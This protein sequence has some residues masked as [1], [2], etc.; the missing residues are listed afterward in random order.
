MFKK[1][2]LA[3]GLAL[4]ATCAQATTFT[5]DGVEY[6]QVAGS[7]VSNYNGQISTF[8]AGTYLFADVLGSGATFAENVAS[9]SATVFSI[10]GPDS[11]TSSTGTLTALYSNDFGI[12]FGSPNPGEELFILHV[13][14]IS[15]LLGSPVD[16]L[17]TAFL[18]TDAT[19]TLT[20]VSEAEVIPLPATLPLILA[21]LGGMAVVSRRRKSAAA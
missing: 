8:T 4:A 21:G 17:T 14:N 10:D 18:L 1:I 5:L 7:T 12:P 13:T 9:V 20:F 16:P 6:E 19:A 3:A 15:D 2:A 11:V